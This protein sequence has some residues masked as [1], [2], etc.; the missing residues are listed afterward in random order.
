[1]SEA[2][3]DSSTPLHP[4]SLVLA[5]TSLLWPLQHLW[6]V[7]MQLSNTLQLLILCSNAATAGRMGYKKK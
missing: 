5:S 1:M 6:A 7:L 2:E 4:P 3:L